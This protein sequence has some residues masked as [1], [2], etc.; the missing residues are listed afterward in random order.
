MKLDIQTYS[1]SHIDAWVHGVD[2][3]GW[4]HL[5][6]FYGEPDT[7]KRV[8]SWQKMKHLCGTSDLPWLIIGDFNEITCVEEKEGGSCRPRQRM[9]NFVDTINWCRLKEVGFVGPRFT[10]LYQREDGIQIRERLDRALATLEWLSLFP[11]AKLFHLTSSAS[12]HSPLSLHFERR[13]PKRKMGRVF[14]FESM[15]LKDSRC[16]EVVHEAWDEGK[17]MGTEFTLKNFL[18]RCRVKL[19]AWN[20]LEFDHVSRMI[21]ELQKKL[22]WLEKQPFSLELSTSL[23]TTRIELN[24]WLEKED[25]MW[26]QRSRI[27]W[28]Q[29]GDRNTRFFHAKASAI[30]KKNLIDGLLDAEG[31]WQED[32]AR[33]EDI[34]VDYYNN[35]FTSNNPTDF[36]EILEA[37]T[38]KV[39]LVMNQSLT[40][41]FSAAKVKLAL[42]Q[43]YPLKVPGPDGMP[44][45]FF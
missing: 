28:L 31:R 13:H 3:V 34:V 2:N 11:S 35:L 17:L 40:R 4:W 36:T 7:S 41:D 6:G 18:D 27:N 45:L 39:T 43:M 42:K 12:D 22:E 9:G 26:R 5:T 38:L 25:E 21:A 37:V 44:P 16:E 23:K 14:R 29:L 15:W 33:I 32:E 30:F 1:S 8:E 24:C 10:W 19:D 20:K